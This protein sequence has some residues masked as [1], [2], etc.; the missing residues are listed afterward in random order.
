MAVYRTTTGVDNNTAVS[1]T[2]LKTYIAGAKADISLLKS[3]EA[4]AFLAN[5]IGKKLVGFRVKVE[6]D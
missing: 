6:E 3:I 1:K 2:S 5:E 4:G